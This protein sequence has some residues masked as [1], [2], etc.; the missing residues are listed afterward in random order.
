MNQKYWQKLKETFNRA[1]ELEGIK[2]EAYLDEACGENSKFR[3]EV[4][5]LLDAFDTPG[6]LDHSLE[7][8]IT[9]VLSHHLPDKK[10][11]IKGE[12]IGPYKILEALGHGGMGNV[13]LAE[14]S[15]GQFEQ[16]VALKLL[17]TDFTSENQTLRFLSERQI[18]A[19]L[20]HE[21][22]AR[23]LD[24]GV[25]E[26][27]QPWFAMEYVEGQ[28][29]D[30]YCD[31][32]QLTIN[33]RLSL[34]LNV[35]DAV[36][37]AHGKLV[38]HRD[39]KPS[40]I[41]VKEDGT[42]KLL[43][44]GIAKVLDSN[45]EFL[46]QAD[47]TKTGLLPLTPAYASPEQV[48]GNSMTTA[49]DIYQLGI[50]LYELLTGCRPYEVSERPPSEVE[51]IICEVQP[52]RPS[53]AITE[54]LPEQKDTKKPL[55][56]ISQD[57]QTKPGQLRK[58]LKGDLDTIILKM[59]RKEPERRYDS[60]EQL[61]YDIRHYLAGRPV[62]AHPDSVGYRAKKF[63]RR[64][65]TG[66]AASTVII[67]LLISYA[68]TITWHSQ[69]TQAALEQSQR[70]TE[71]AE[72]VTHFLISL[73]EQANPYRQN[74]LSTVYNDTLTTYELLNQGARRVRKE[75]SD[76][77]VVQA[78]VMY[79]LGRIYRMLG[80]FDKAKPLLEDALTVQRNN[81]STNAL[82]LADNLH[83]LA[84]LLRNEGEIKRPT[85]LYHE[86]LE[87]Q[88]RHLGEEHADIAKNLYELG[89]IAARKG[90]FDQADSLFKEGLAI[91]KSVHGQDHPDVATGL[92]LLGI[93]YNLKEEVHKAEQLLQQSLDIRKNHVSSDHPEIAETMD[94]LGQV[95]LK[96]GKIKEAEPLLNKAW[97]IRKKLFQK[98]HPTR[99]VSLN[100]MGRLLHKKGN[101]DKADLML[102]E[103]QNI[104][105]ELYG[106]E[107]LD[108]ATTLMERAKLYKSM[109]EYSTSERFYKQALSI[110]NSLYGRENYY[111]QQTLQ[112]LSELYKTWGKSPKPD[113]LQLHNFTEL[114]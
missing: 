45:N 62:K 78:K 23:L 105:K 32:H 57:R 109:E 86:A 53:T 72:Q 41:L 114:N 39:L 64:Y 40:N 9:T 8:F 102:Q 59:L 69:R 104:Y 47:I 67:L 84:R 48:C 30:E 65:K 74:E 68:V 20:N 50:V 89:I 110:Q 33:E 29:I 111:T 46:N 100:N 85:K 108:I 101:F 10:A 58:H 42:V 87:I 79:K 97:D 112:K 49:S 75:L 83:E 38:V 37:S 7:G 25:T 60:A 106:Q 113:S 26:D 5:S 99:A 91:Q 92:H 56:D 14:R 36:Q 44:F 31:N 15:D 1:L 17:Q 34:F 70:E 88:R 73:F 93:L 6:I 98:T 51:R 103:A 28:P 27:G 95:L 12:Q 77:P 24:G 94:R 81:P 55:Q 80:H 71:K 52:T 4:I 90:S 13:Y 61:A 35:C 43:D 63:I 54:V 21:N 3:E 22:I 11:K 76:Q 19:T 18:L 2:R 66:V 82:D 107:N 96:Q 16:Q